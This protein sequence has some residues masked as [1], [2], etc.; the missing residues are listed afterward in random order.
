MV[1]KPKVGFCK[2]LN[3]AGDGARTRDIQLGKMNADT[4]EIQF[5][6]KLRCFLI[7]KK[8]CKSYAEIASF[9]AWSSTLWT[10]AT[11]Y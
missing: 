10:E 1:H 2:L 9:F 8:V 11:T 5:Y 3:K 6:N 4:T 7:I